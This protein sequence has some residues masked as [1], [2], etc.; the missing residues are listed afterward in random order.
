MGQKDC[1]H[2][3]NHGEDAWTLK[4][5][6]P[7]WSGHNLSFDTVGN[8]S[9]E[10]LSLENFRVFGVNEGDYS[11]FDYAD[12]DDDDVFLMKVTIDTDVNHKP[13]DLGDHQ[14]ETDYEQ[15]LLKDRFAWF[16]G[17]VVF[18]L[19]GFK[20]DSATLAIN[21]IVE[22]DG[23]NFAEFNLMKD[24]LRRNKRPIVNVHESLCFHLCD[25]VID[26]IDCRL[27]ATICQYLFILGQVLKR[28]HIM[29]VI[30]ASSSKCSD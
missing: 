22:V 15:A 12:E 20:L 7:S 30:G 4:S 13:D 1:T 5:E 6:I 11:E 27:V 14:D 3:L 10:L 28:L 2:V 19:I 17:E 23:V 26:S 25:L 8:W 16:W 21:I 9:N 18:G 29:V 24:K